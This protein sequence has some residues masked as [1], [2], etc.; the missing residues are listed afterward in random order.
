MRRERFF[1]PRTESRA[2]KKLTIFQ[3]ARKKGGIGGEAGGAGFFGPTPP[4]T[5][6]PPFSGPVLGNVAC[7]YNHGCCG[8]ANFLKE[9]AEKRFLAL[10]LKKESTMN[11]PSVSN[12]P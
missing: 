3:N 10:I 2:N 8:V 4:S 6:S 1:A 9:G 5:P 12:L 11:R 7:D